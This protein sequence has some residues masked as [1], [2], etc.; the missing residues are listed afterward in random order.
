MKLELDNISVELKKRT[1]EFA[2]NCI[3]VIEILP[4][5]YLGNHIKGEL[6]SCSTSVATNFRAT[7]VAN[8]KVSYLNKISS[9][10]ITWIIDKFIK[11]QLNFIN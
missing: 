9:V 10:I 7:C 4:N 3:K 6:I 2:L 5:T 1:K 11:K 8:N